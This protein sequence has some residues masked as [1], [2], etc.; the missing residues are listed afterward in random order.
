MPR[1]FI[2]PPCSFLVA[3]LPKA[4]LYSSSPFLSTE[5]AAAAAAVMHGPLNL[6]RWKFGFRLIAA[7]PDK[8][9]LVP[10]KVVL[11]M[12]VPW[13]IRKKDMRKGRGKT[14]DFR[15]I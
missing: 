6:I 12:P 10:K 8:I 5:A 13:T 14:E 4:L 1:A 11:K 3:E 15:D 2:C 9:F 7:D